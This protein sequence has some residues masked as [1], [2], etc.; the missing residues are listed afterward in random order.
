MVHE[1]RAR[2]TPKGDATDPVSAA[3]NPL[4]GLNGPLVGWS[5]DPLSRPADPLSRPA[6]PPSPTRPTPLDPPSERVCRP[7]ER[8]RPTHR[9]VLSPARRGSRLGRLP[10]SA[11]SSRGTVGAPD[12]APALAPLRYAYLRVHDPTAPLSAACTVFVRFRTRS[13]SYVSSYPLNAAASFGWGRFQSG[14]SL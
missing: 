1:E 6:D 2:Q 9:A 5:G 12:P 8:C 10:L 3:K 7:H 13:Y 11:G 4:W 14:R